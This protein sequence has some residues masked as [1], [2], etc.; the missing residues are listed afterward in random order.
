MNSKNGLLT[1]KK[2]IKGQFQ[3]DTVRVEG[4]WHSVLIVVKA[5]DW[6]GRGSNLP[7]IL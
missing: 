7:D 3:R 5:H 1:V 2:I 6:L 4:A